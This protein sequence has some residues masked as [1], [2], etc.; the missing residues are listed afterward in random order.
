MS[1]MFPQDAVWVSWTG[2]L[3]FEKLG[4]VCVSGN[5]ISLACPCQRGISS[6]AAREQ[7]EDRKEGD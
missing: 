5:G 4:G 3:P 7:R 1:I 6:L 2:M